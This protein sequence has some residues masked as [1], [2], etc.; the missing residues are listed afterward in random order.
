MKSYQKTRERSQFTLILKLTRNNQRESES[1]NVNLSCDDK[2]NL[3]IFLALIST[4]M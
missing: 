4:S 3:S 2:C 1:F